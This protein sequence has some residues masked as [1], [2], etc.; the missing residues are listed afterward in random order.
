V[1]PGNAFAAPWAREVTFLSPG[2]VEIWTWFGTDRSGVIQIWEAGDLRPPVHSPEE[3]DWIDRVRPDW[4]PEGSFAKLSLET[5][6]RHSTYENTPDAMC[7]GVFRVYISELRAAL[8]LVRIRA[9]LRPQLPAA[10]GPVADIGG[11]PG[12]HA[13]W[14]HAQGYAVDLLDPIP[15][16]VQAAPRYGAPHRI[17]VAS[18]YFSLSSNIA[19][20]RSTISFPAI[21]AVTPVGSS[22]GATST[23]STPTIRPRRASA[24]NASRIS[25]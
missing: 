6:E 10:P 3:R 14:P 11:G 21:L 24:R 17:E 13:A 15:R 19:D 8:E 1:P 18:T 9:L 25:S 2:A 23:R 5:F 7:A 4:K 22:L 12:V 16:H 20:K